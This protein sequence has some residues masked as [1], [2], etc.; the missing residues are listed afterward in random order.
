MAA[1]RSRTSGGDKRPATRGKG[2]GARPPPERTVKA[3]DVDIAPPPDLL[4]DLDVNAL[5]RSVALR[6]P[7]RA[8]T[9]L[10]E[11]ADAADFD[12]APTGAGRRSAQDQQKEVIQAIVRR[13]SNEFDR[14]TRTGT[15]SQ[16][17]LSD[18]NVSK[19]MAAEAVSAAARD[20]EPFDRSG[21]ATGV[22][23]LALAALKDLPEASGPTMAFDQEGPAPWE[24]HPG[25]AH[26]VM[27]APA[28]APSRPGTGA[29]RLDS[30]ASPVPTSLE[31]DRG[32][33]AHTRLKEQLGTS[34]GTDNGKKLH[35][36]LE[37]MLER[38]SVGGAP[39]PAQV[40]VFKDTLAQTL[41][42]RLGTTQVSRLLDGL[43][44]PSATGGGA[45]VRSGRGAMPLE[46]LK[47]VGRVAT[48][49]SNPAMDVLRVPP[50]PAEPTAMEKPPVRRAP[51]AP[52]AADRTV[53][54][55]PME[56]LDEADLT[57]DSASSSVTTRAQVRALK[58]RPKSREN[59]RDDALA[60]LERVLPPDVHPRLRDR[61]VSMVER[62]LQA[63]AVGAQVADPEDALDDWVL[64]MR[65][66]QGAN[67]ADKTAVA[68]LEAMLGVDRLRG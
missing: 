61:L 6:D 37:K 31:A 10:F 4:G 14:V 49:R 5:L 43:L 46:D 33:R 44:E 66:A 13:A 19:R 57:F 62:F 67:G 21:T 53:V 42:T 47:R 45:V 55:E 9:E 59:V 11:K 25:S 27:Q 40:D 68:T 30:F 38:R 8:L 16:A 48:G 36:L 18:P 51:V 32:L 28:R 3:R 24:D 7:R 26:V 35:R 41:G 50:V 54:A 64:T 12:D 1:A 56:D 52:S 63:R 23:R 20:A 17:Q 34:D 65:M 22:M 58:A 29:R 2:T 60:L 15:F 39:T